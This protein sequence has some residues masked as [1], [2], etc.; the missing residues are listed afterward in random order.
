MCYNSTTLGFNQMWMYFSR[1]VWILF[2]IMTAHVA[3]SRQPPRILA[4]NVDQ[5]GAVSVPVSSTLTLNCEGDEPVGWVTHQRKDIE[6]RTVEEANIEKNADNKYESK[7][8]VQNTV[9]TDTGPFACRYKASMDSIQPVDNSEI[10]VFVNDPKNLMLPIEGSHVIMAAT[11]VDST[12]PCRPTDRN[13]NMTLWKGPV[14]NGK[15]L[16]VN[17]NEIQY[18]PTR[19]FTFT[20][21]TIMHQDDYH[22]VA[23]LGDRS[24]KLAYYVVVFQA[25]ASLPVPVISQQAQFA[26]LNSKF[27]ISCSVRTPSSVLLFLDWDFPAGKNSQRVIMGTEWSTEY[28]DIQGNKYK[29]IKLN[30]TIPSVGFED[31]GT[32]TCTVKDHTSNFNRK[33]V[34]VDVKD[35]GESFIR[36]TLGEGDP[37]LPFE[38]PLHFP[39]VKFVVTY[40]AYPPE[41]VLRWFKGSKQLS[42]STKYRI[43][44]EDK[45]STLIVYNLTR[46]DTGFYT[47]EGETGQTREKLELTLMVVEPPDVMIKPTLPQMFKTKERFVIKCIIEG[48]PSSNISWH[49]SPCNSPRNCERNYHELITSEQ[50]EEEVTEHKGEISDGCSVTSIISGYAFAAGN[51]KCVAQNEV[52]VNSSERSMFIK[53]F[54]FGFWSS[55]TK[56]NPFEQD[57]LELNCYASLFYYSNVEWYWLSSNKLPEDQPIKITNNSNVGVYTSET[58]YTLLVDIEI[59]PVVLETSGTYICRA[60]AREGGKNEEKKTIISVQKTTSPVIMD[61]N[62]NNTEYTVFKEQHFEFICRASGVPPPNITWYLN[63]TMIKTSNDTAIQF[64]ENGAK[65][66]I[67]RTLPS[68]SGRYLC[69]ASNRAGANMRNATLIVLDVEAASPLSKGGIIGI[70]VFI[71]VAVVVIIVGGVFLFRRV[72]RERKDKAEWEQLQHQLFDEGNLQAYNPELPLDEQVSTLP[73]DKSWEIPK[74]RLRLGRQLGQGAFGRVVKGELYIPEKQSWQNVAVKM[75]KERSDNEQ[76]RALMQ[77]LKIMIHIGRHIN[78]VNLIGAITKNLSKGELQVL[79]E[80]CKYGNL[81]HYLLKH[82]E[83]FISQIHLKTGEFDESVERTEDVFRFSDVY[84]SSG[85]NSSEITGG[86]M[87]INS[88]G[89]VDNPGARLSGLASP[90]PQSARQLSTY[91]LICF[92]YQVVSG[93]IY[94]SSRKLVHRDLALR[95]ILLAEGD[96]VKICDFGLA[97]DVYTKNYYRK[98]GQGPLP[99]KWM[100]IES[101]RDKIYTVESDVWS[102]SILLWELFTL[103]ANP[104]PGIEVDDEFYH[105]LCNGYRM[106]KPSLA[107]N[108]IYNLMSQCWVHEPKMRPT[109]SQIITKLSEIMNPETVQNYQR[110]N[111]EYLLLDVGVGKCPEYLENLEKDLDAYVSID[112]D[113]VMNDEHFYQNSEADPSSPVNV[114]MQAGSVNYANLLHPNN[115]NGLSQQRVL[116]YGDPNTDRPELA[117]MIGSGHYQLP[118]KPVKLGTVPQ[119]PSKQ[120]I[121][122]NSGYLDMGSKFNLADGHDEGSGKISNGTPPPRY[123]LAI[124]SDQLGER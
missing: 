96:V 5:W 2:A 50:N 100:A 113:A 120:N 17:N 43:Y 16:T 63:G 3:V 108:S 18:D 31:E 34:Y 81:R 73:Y 22:C 76:R 84:N 109:F 33:S 103:G 42:N 70:S 61:T 69:V 112:S 58:L 72:Y 4:S 65:L 101:I 94:L 9:Y 105:K 95:N 49:W 111:E 62:L 15:P 27:V 91:D 55:A 38:L 118:P 23:T 39:E 25:P 117:P 116:K 97:K 47:L 79:V 14:N 68:D 36:F 124:A 87:N 99:Y 59:N 107:P 46:P 6:E 30:L 40:L 75:L 12:I 11:N 60:T 89:G 85:T 88:G 115:A 13:V 67:A 114:N 119:P 8:V 45:R 86:T 19:G 37:N 41:P 32:Y 24:D 28:S 123:T 77:E 53:D 51:Y 102:F 26:T 20:V 7:L 106:A 104:Y 56:T 98:R 110:Q 93:M 122:E 54:I 90:N 64:L 83:N 80:F 44:N 66:V 29:E 78:V 52:G 71:I 57:N 35:S 74:E 121:V 92:S 82:R 48:C 1:V 21:V 10:Y